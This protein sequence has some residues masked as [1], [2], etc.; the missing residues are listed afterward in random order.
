MHPGMGSQEIGVLLGLPKA[1][2]HHLYSEI[3]NDL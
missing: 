2:Y 3:N 1:E